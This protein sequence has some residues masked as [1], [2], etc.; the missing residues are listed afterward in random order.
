MRETEWRT[1]FI[2]VLKYEALNAS[3]CSFKERGDRDAFTLKN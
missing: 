3:R 2:N 1:R